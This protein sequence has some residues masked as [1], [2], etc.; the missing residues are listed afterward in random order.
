MSDDPRVGTLTSDDTAETE[1]AKAGLA[2]ASSLTF[3]FT[4]R[5]GGVAM[6]SALDAAVAMASSVTR[7]RTYERK[8]DMCSALGGVVVAGTGS[9]STSMLTSAV[10][11]AVAM[12]PTAVSTVASREGEAARIV[13]AE[14]TGN[15]ASPTASGGT[16]G[17]RGV[18]LPPVPVSR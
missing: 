3:M 7:R 14:A 12:A 17:K 16:V 11:D 13:T 5:E 10:E 4:S 2:V 15:V 6:A 8:E 18:E 1:A 9:V